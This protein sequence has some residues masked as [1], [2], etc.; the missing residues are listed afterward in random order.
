V[1]TDSST[2]EEPELT[3]PR[4]PRFW[5][6][7]FGW[8][9]AM[10]VGV[11][12]ACV[13]LLLFSDVQR[14][15][16]QTVL[17]VKGVM[18]SKGDFFADKEVQELLRSHNI[19][20]QVSR[21]GSREAALEVI[22]EPDKYDFAFPSGTP[23]A[24]QIEAHRGQE[25]R[26]YDT[27]RLFSSPIVLASYRDYAETLVRNGIAT[28]H[29]SDAGPPLYYTL[30]TAKFVAL[31]DAGAR[32]NQIGMV[33]SPDRDPSGN[34]VLADSSG[35]CRSNSALTYLALL[36]F[37]KNG[38]N[39][40]VAGDVDR[41]VQQ[42]RPLFEATGLAESELF[43]TYVTPEGEGQGPVVVVYEHQFL[44]Y[45]IGYRQRTGDLDT[46][47]VLLYPTEEFQAD[48]DF[49]SFNESGKKL[50]DLLATDARLRKRMMELGYRV[51]D[52]T[53][54]TSTTQ[55]LEHLDV[56]QV[57]KPAPR[58]ELTKAVFPPSSEVLDALMHGIG[59]CTQ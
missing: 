9:F 46:T 31:G 34:R 59:R 37:V 20:V 30:D 27:E 7:P 54:T 58:R 48:A 19:R 17:T 36:A 14:P 6:S 28:A 22:G 44:V 15:A 11:A 3:I 26:F 43:R 25:K 41:L 47:R 42:L 56:M 13:V 8:S 57:P 12:L 52:D 1:K 29:A 38:G 55:M 18:A 4:A 24:D 51:L 10:T 50:S 21:R 40:P 2:D 16:A 53:N 45:Q 5:A 39:V 33:A 32:W 35:V 49:I 23:T